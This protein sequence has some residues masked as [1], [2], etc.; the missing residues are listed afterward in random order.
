MRDQ[1]DKDFENMGGY[2][3]STFDSKI[4][5]MLHDAGKGHLVRGLV[6]GPRGQVP[7]ATIPGTTPLTIGGPWGQVTRAT[8]PGTTP[9]T[10]GH[11]RRN[12]VRGNIYGNGIYGDWDAVGANQGTAGRGNVELIGSNQETAG[13]G[14]VELVGAA[15][16]PYYSSQATRAQLR[17]AQQTFV[18]K[19]ANQSA[20]KEIVTEQVP[21]AQLRNVRQTFVGKGRGT[22]PGPSP[23]PRS[24]KKEV[25]SEQTPRAQLR[26]I[27]QTFIGQANKANK[28]LKKIMAIASGQRISKTL[29]ERQVPGH[30]VEKYLDSWKDAYRT[31]FAKAPAGSE[32]SDEQKKVLAM[33]A[34][35]GGQVVGQIAVVGDWLA[36]AGKFMGRAIGKVAEL[37]VRMTGKAAKALV[38]DIPKAAFGIGKGVFFDPVKKTFFKKKG[39]K[40]V[41]VSMPVPSDYYENPAVARRVMG[42]GDTITMPST[43]ALAARIARRKRLT[44]V[45]HQQLTARIETAR[46]RSRLAD[47]EMAEANEVKRL[48]GEAAAAEAEA[49]QSEADMV[50]EERG[51]IGGDL[52][53]SKRT[54]LM[55]AAQEAR[56]ASK[57]L[58]AAGPFAKLAILASPFRAAVI[59]AGKIFI[60][61]KKDPRGGQK[62]AMLK[63]AQKAGDPE[64][65][66]VLDT[67]KIGKKTVEEL[68]AA[69]VAE[70]ELLKKIA[71]KEGASPT[72]VGMLPSSEK[73]IVAIPGAKLVYQRAKA[74]DE[75][76][77]ALVREAAKILREAKAGDASAR[78]TLASLQK[79]AQADD[80]AGQLGMAAMAVA[81]AGI[82]EER[83]EYIPSIPPSSL[84]RGKAKIKTPVASEATK[85]K[86]R[87]A[88]TLKPIEKGVTSFL[89]QLTAADQHAA[90][91]QIK[92]AQAQARKKSWSQGWAV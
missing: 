19:K 67:L 61:A 46:N 76:M 69:K 1:Q 40:A 73:V 62:V 83:T 91:V 87:L 59:A 42:P 21:R 53:P 90:G 35:A 84:L 11:L 8:I 18:G 3:G 16:P 6:G 33:I 47:L 92:I 50:E 20:R 37:G 30:L 70:K 80:K 81:A 85:I 38:W 27:R 75:K 4:A 32:V 51:F 43:E 77:I 60:D 63:E 25:W 13:R 12:G 56:V 72:V 5:D 28:R 57:V 31:R 26:N 52:R 45:Q 86:E 41:S 29:G 79:K 9:L 17:T 78:A 39:G 88:A 23:S 65:E 54:S 7:R 82:R 44:S 49:A 14:N 74:G 58:K 66:K 55:G 48:E 34:Q 68:E 15:K 36:D 64:A 24:Q 10:I 2:R 22:S 71:E 89:S